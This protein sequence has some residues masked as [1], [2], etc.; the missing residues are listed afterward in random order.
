L[1]T[2]L[3][4]PVD[5]V[6]FQTHIILQSTP[7]NRF[8]HFRKIKRGLTWQRTAF[9]PAQWKRLA[10]HAREKGLIFSVHRLRRQSTC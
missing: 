6:K 7:A 10:D 5:A 3:R 8:A 4:P 2:R 1:W 9:S